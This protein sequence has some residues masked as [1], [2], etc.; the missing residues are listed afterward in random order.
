MLKA[1]IHNVLA[2]PQSKAAAPPPPGTPPPPPP[3]AASRCR[4]L[5]SWAQSTPYPLACT[6][7]SWRG[8]Y[9]KLV[10]AQ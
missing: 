7:G 10:G 5:G 4:V 3:G 6:S 2:P 8:Q 9:L 1:N